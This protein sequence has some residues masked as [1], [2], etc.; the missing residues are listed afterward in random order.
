[1]NLRPR[2]HIR[3]PPTTVINNAAAAAP[4]VANLQQR[5]EPRHV[6]NQRV[7]KLK[8]NVHMLKI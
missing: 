6:N 2:T 3:Y 5:P 8:S 1:M 7:H 4:T